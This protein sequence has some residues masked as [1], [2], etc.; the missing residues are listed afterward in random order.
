MI[1]ERALRCLPRSYKLWFK[2]LME[3]KNQ[4]KEYPVSDVKYELLIGTFQRA[5]VCLLLNVCPIVMS[6]SNLMIDLYA[7]NATNLE[8]ICCFSN[9]YW[10]S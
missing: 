7:Q 8:R 6:F 1:Y 5:L 4:L 3:R 10:D 9:R 2:Y